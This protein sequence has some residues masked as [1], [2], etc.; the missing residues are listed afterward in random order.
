MDAVLRFSCSFRS[1]VDPRFMIITQWLDTMKA[2]QGDL[3]S[4]EPA[5]RVAV[6]YVRGKTYPIK[7]KQLN[8]TTMLETSDI[9]GS[10]E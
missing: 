7:N 3:K 10:S 2:L 8:N 9:Y 6:F 1:P 4:W 5:L